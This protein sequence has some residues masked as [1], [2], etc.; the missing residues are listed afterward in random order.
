MTYW[1]HFKVELHLKIWSHLLK[2]KS[3]SYLILCLVIFKTLNLQ[4]LAQRLQTGCNRLRPPFLQTYPGRKTS[5]MFDLSLSSFAVHK[6][7][8][9]NKNRAVLIWLGRWQRAVYSL[10]SE[11]SIWA[12]QPSR[13]HV[14]HKVK[15]WFISFSLFS[16]TQ[17][18][19]IFSSAS[20]F[21]VL[22]F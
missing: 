18:P 11:A 5:V 9:A 21:Q 4:E 10:Q 22:R 19:Q 12:A 7:Q 8:K 20:V 3:E 16:Y 1:K 2:N 15:E 14:I 13:Q 17:Q 6:R